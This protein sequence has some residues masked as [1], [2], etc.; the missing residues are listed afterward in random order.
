MFKALGTSNCLRKGTKDIQKASDG[1]NKGL[2]SKESYDLE[3]WKSRVK[4]STA[5][6]L[7]ELGLAYEINSI[8]AFSLAI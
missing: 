2:I 3:T 1:V 6:S 8:V 5:K 7:T 4:V